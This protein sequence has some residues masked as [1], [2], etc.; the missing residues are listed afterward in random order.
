M[1]RL[2]LNPENIPSEGMINIKDNKSFIPPEEIINISDDALLNTPLEDLP[3]TIHFDGNGVAKM[4][5]HCENNNDCTIDPNIAVSKQFI[6][7]I[8]GEYWLN[9]ETLSYEIGYSYHMVVTKEN[10]SYALYIAGEQVVYINYM[11]GLCNS[12][13]SMKAGCELSKKLFKTIVG[14]Y[15][16][17]KQDVNVPLIIKDGKLNSVGTPVHIEIA[18]KEEGFYSLLWDGR[19]VVTCC[20]W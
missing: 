8:V 15:K 14:R 11:P 1:K 20:L 12:G 16:A 7:S 17:T 18:K 9:K 13:V 10:N 2:N 4:L 5:F 3:F 6:D 19:E